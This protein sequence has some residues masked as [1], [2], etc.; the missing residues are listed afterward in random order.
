[1]IRRLELCE[2]RFEVKEAFK[3]GGGGM[4]VIVIVGRGVGL[5]VCSRR[6]DSD[7]TS[8]ALTVRWVEGVGLEW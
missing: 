1:M 7:G 5:G 2:L 8:T 4:F 3:A 6:G